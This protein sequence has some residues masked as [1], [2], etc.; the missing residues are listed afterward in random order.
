MPQIER[1]DI[2]K[3]I[4]RAQ[5]FIIRQQLPDGGYEWPGLQSEAW[6]TAECVLATSLPTVSASAK[7]GLA[8]LRQ[9]VRADGG[10]SSEAYKNVTGGQSDVA[11][12]AY[13]TR[14]LSCC[15]VASD[16]LLVEGGRDWLVRSQRADGSW[17]VARPD[18][19]RAQVG[20]T[21][22]AVSALA[23]APAE[24][25]AAEAL[26]AAL[27]FLYDSQ[28]SSGG[29]GLAPGHKV[30]ATLTA[31][32]LR[33][34][35]DVAVLRGQAPQAKTFLRW[36]ANVQETQNAD[37]S[38]SDWY[39]NASSVEAA[40]YAVEIASS[41][42]VAV[43]G[44]GQYAPWLGRALEFLAN[45]QH[46]DGGW[47]VDPHRESSHWVTHSVVI[48]LSSLLGRADRVVARLELL[49]VL[50]DPRRQRIETAGNTLK[51]DFAISFSGSQRMFARALALKL[52][53]RGATVFFDAFE[54]A[55]LWGSNLV[56]R[57]T[58]VYRQEASLCV[59]I[60]SPD[61]PERAW[62][63]L[64]RRSALARALEANEDYVLPIRVGGETPVPGLLD[65]VG[66]LDADL[67]DLDDIAAMAM[68]KLRAGRQD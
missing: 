61:Y 11:A 14:A 5:R 49:A 3:S 10:W 45:A 58:Q 35:I 30:D 48:A 62:P 2:L 41:L 18:E 16:R 59:M 52:Q 65:T 57:L 36:L 40:G 47:G 39:G 53:Q 19:E 22:Y 20:Q 34:L 60:V 56:E 46:S 38:W 29:W 23:Y 13:A 43:E 7:R 51:Y 67:Y 4:R 50:D 54:S 31:Y 1:E 26:Q 68:V 37:G 9:G 55:E 24:H 15:G 17:G 25:R 44:D 12:T 28:R 42:G 21:G 33:G 27:Y 6:G 66:Y 64:E 63:R 8:W 32:V